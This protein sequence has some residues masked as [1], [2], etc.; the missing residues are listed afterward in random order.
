MEES[1]HDDLLL[2]CKRNHTHR[3]RIEIVRRIENLRAIG[4]HGEAVHLGREIDMISGPRQRRLE[5][6]FA[7]CIERNVHEEID[8]GNEAAGIE[9]VLG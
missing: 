7:I 5:L 8:V 9:P 6:E 4:D 2:P 3:R 1:H